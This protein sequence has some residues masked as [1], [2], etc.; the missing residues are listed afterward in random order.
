MQATFAQ[1]Y[2]YWVK[3]QVCSKAIR[4]TLNIANQ[5]YKH[6]QHRHVLLS[7]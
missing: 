1:D 2:V 4:V 6:C 3:E 7:K 5:A